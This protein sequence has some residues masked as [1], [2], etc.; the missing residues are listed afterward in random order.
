MQSFL[1]FVDTAFQMKFKSINSI[2][3]IVFALNAVSD[4]LK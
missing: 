3:K 2:F 4:N 1:F